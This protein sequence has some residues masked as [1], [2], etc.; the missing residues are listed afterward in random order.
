MTN[1]NLQREPLAVRGL[2]LAVVNVL[3]VFGVVSFT[4][5]QT[6]TLVVAIDAALSV[7]ALVI[8]GRPAV[9][10]VAAPRLDGEAVFIE[11]ELPEGVEVALVDDDEVPVSGEDI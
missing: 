6:D 9:T 11:E 8:W 4:D 7:A 2:I 3:I 10:P 1:L 5:A